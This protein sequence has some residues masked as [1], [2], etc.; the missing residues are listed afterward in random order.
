MSRKSLIAWVVGVLGLAVG[1]SRGPKVAALGHIGM[2]SVS[3][4][5]PPRKQKAPV[6]G[7]LTPELR[8]KGF[9]ECNP[10]DPLG[11]GPYAPFRPLPLGR[12]L[13][14]QKGG[15][16]PDMGYDVLIHFHGADAVR[17]LLVQ[18]ARGLVLVLVDKGFGGGGP[19]TQA[20]GTQL[21]FPLLR[22]SIEQALREHSGSEQAHIR[23]LAISSWS[24]GAEA[25]H[26]LLSQR[27]E[28]ID[29]V[30]VLDGLHGAW[31]QGEPRVQRPESLDARFI[32]REIAFAERARRGE[33]L[34]VLTY[35]RVDPSVFPSTGATA[36]LLLRELRLTPTELA[37]ASQPFAQTSAVD[38]AGLHVWGFGGK[39][40]TA[41]CAQLFVM[42]RIVTE[43][44]EPAWDTPAMDRSVPPTP[45]PDW[46]FKRH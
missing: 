38:V 21:V 26:K 30:I 3:S 39:D 1:C 29:A 22:R 8:A 19:Y 40:Q 17:K 28:G 18:T 15:H 25:I 9:S 27:Q 4:I 24:A 6:V 14:P 35:S 37:P 43:I 41:H 5:E 23:H 7:A 45:H 20:L 42:P 12:L 10:H 32:E 33:A 36:E 13:I 46:R 44:L 31:K 16:T 34:F 11:L 2:P